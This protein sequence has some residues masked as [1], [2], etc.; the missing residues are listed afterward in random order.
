MT[1]SQYENLAQ[2]QA[3]MKVAILGK[4]PDLPAGWYGFATTWPWRW[5]QG[6]S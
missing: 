4:F 5:R 3:G 1:L 2:V 6:R